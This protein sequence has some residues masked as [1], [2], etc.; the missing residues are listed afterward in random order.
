[1]EESK[2]AVD[3]K[4]VEDVNQSIK[5]NTRLVPVDGVKFTTYD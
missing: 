1:L 5:T 3:M 2:E 4:G